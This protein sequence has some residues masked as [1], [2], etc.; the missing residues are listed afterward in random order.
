MKKGI[1]FIVAVVVIGAF[2]LIQ[3]KSSPDRATVSRVADPASHRST[4]NGD[5]VGFKDDF[6]TYAWRGIPFAKPPVGDL[7][8]KAPVPV[9]NWL[10][11]KQAIEVGNFCPQLGGRLVDSIP[12]KYGK[13][14]GS[15]DCLYLNIWAPV[16]ASN[17]PVA[18]NV[19]PIAQSDRPNTLVDAVNKEAKPV[20]FWIHG[21]GNSIGHGGS[22]SY[23]G[24]NMASTHGMI[25]VTINY[26]LGPFGWFTHPALR[27]A[28]SSVLDQSGNFGTLDI[29]EALKWVKTNIAQFGGDPEN[30]TIF[31]ESAGGFDVLSMMASPYAKGL[32]H[33]AIVQSGALNLVPMSEAENYADSQEVGSTWSSREVINKLLIADGIAA[34]RD[35]AKTHQNA[36]SHKEIREYLFNKS[37]YDFFSVFTSTEF[38]MLGTPNLFRDGYVLP[39][40]HTVEEIFSDTK[41]YNVTPVILGTNRD[42]MKLFLSFDP[43]NQKKLFGIPYGIADEDAYERTNRYA[44]DVWKTKGVDEI[45]TYLRSAQGESVYTYRFDWDEEGM[46]FLFDLSKALGAAHGL[47]IAFVFGNFASSF[48]NIYPSEGI[49]ARDEL[50]AAMMKYWTDFAK[51]GEPGSGSIKT[52][53]TAWQNEGESSKRLLIFD[54][55][56][57]GGVRMSSERLTL[58]S[59]KNRF[60]SDQTFAN[61]EEK[62]LAYK[63]FFI[64]DDFQLAEYQSLGSCSNTG[65]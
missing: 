33:K 6:D 54:T 18:K 63:Q 37:T 43:K 16:D 14:V 9:E 42:E 47:E 50:S 23:N 53:W 59:I 62:C 13:P 19:L 30:V 38:G 7:R 51:T 61:L 31:G 40:E 57:D 11:E 1:I 26:R 25:V 55:A 36:M 65:L 22:D 10:E 41:N 24:A 3:L 64:G 15:E 56:A 17:M 29:V 52:P 39:K 4:A 49:P 20:M 45:A 21:G 27:D 58:S 35:T 60:M 12:E 48:L 2:M 5:V 8:W 44:T 32:Y 28:T 46:A 34:N